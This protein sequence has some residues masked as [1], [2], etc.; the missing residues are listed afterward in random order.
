MKVYL[1]TKTLTLH[2]QKLFQED[3]EAAVELNPSIISVIFSLLWRILLVLGCTGNCS[4]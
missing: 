2:H 1:N 4:R 3:L